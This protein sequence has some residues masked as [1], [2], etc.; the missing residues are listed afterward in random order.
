MVTSI[1]PRIIKSG[2]SQRSFFMVFI[3]R[4]LPQKAAGPQAP[5]PIF[6]TALVFVRFGH[7]ANRIIKADES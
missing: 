5:S 4:S 6:E 2:N 3:G 1:A 7:V